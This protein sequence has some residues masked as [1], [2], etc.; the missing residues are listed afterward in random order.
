MPFGC[1][2]GGAIG[3]EDGTSK[4]SHIPIRVMEDVVAVYAGWAVITSDNVLRRW[5]DGSPIADDVIAASFSGDTFMVITSDGTLWGRGSN[6]SGALGDGTRNNRREPIKI[7][8]NVVSVSTS[9]RHTLAVT[10][11]GNLWA[12]GENSLGQLGIGT[13]RGQYEAAR[14]LRETFW[15]SPIMVM[16]YVPEG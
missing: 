10:S 12:W 13:H 5:T 15:L 4:D 3:L 16:E 6:N 2:G 7:M 11:D 1:G 8:E 14:G 9:G